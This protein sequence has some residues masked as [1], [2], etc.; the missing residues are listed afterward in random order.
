MKKRTIVSGIHGGS[1][2]GSSADEA[3]IQSSGPGAAIAL[4]VVSF[5]AVQ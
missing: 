5:S 4:L 1:Q 2:A 3:G